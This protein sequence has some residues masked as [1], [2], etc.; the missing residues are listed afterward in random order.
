[1]SENF[2]F[3]TQ[4]PKEGKMPRRLRFAPPGYWLHL[5]QLGTNKQP[6]FTPDEGP[7]SFPHL[8]RHA[9]RRAPSSG[10]RLQL[11]DQSLSPRRR[12]RPERCHLALYDGLRRIERRPRLLLPL[13]RC[14]RL[15]LRPRSSRHSQVGVTKAHRWLDLHQFPQRWPT[16]AP[17]PADREGEPRDPHSPRSRRPP[18]GHAPGLRLR[19]RRLH[20][21]PRAHPPDP[22]PRSAPRPAS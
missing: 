17:T 18:P 11:D 19:Y 1:M 14:L 13:G 16:P 15:V 21:E 9:Q 8:L 22:A 20:R 3:K 10:S 4:L 7:P 12:R 6:V 2:P 5:T